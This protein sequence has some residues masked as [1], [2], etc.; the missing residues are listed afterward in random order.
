LNEL[1]TL[2]GSDKGWSGSAKTPFPWKPH[3]YA[4]FYEILL[5]SRRGLVRQVIE[6]GIGTNN[7]D[8]P[9]HMTSSGQPGAS[10]RAWRDYFPSAQVIGLDIDERILFTEQRIETYAVDQTDQLQVADLWRE[11]RLSSVDLV[12]DDGLH[13]FEAG[14]KFFEAAFPILAKHG[15]YVIEDVQPKSLRD[16]RHYFADRDELVWFVQI[17]RS[18]HLIGDNSLVIVQHPSPA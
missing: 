12:I 11:L 14:V 6:C 4:D 10:L 7:E 16:F 2:H 9:G 15:I 5:S 17:Q 1:F 3:N 8:V 18:S 13:T